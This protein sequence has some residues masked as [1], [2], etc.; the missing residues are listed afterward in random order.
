[1]SAAKIFGVLEEAL[2]RKRQTKKHWTKKEPILFYGALAVCSRRKRLSAHSF[3]LNP[4]RILSGLMIS[5]LFTSIPSEPSTAYISSSVISGILSLR[6]KLLYNKP[7]VLKNF[8]SGKPLCLC[9]FFNSAADGFFSFIN[10]SV[11]LILW[12]SSHF[13][14][15]MQVVHLG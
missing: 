5:G 9:H 14:A 1:M 11:Y 3:S 8:L 13:L 15:L 10:R 4:I 6:F 7:L 2:K 12:S